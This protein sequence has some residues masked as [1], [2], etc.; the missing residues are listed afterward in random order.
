[1]IATEKLTTN[2]PIN[3]PPEKIPRIGSVAVLVWEG[4]D[5]ALNMVKQSRIVEPTL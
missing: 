1:M 2:Q 3:Q 4:H 5:I